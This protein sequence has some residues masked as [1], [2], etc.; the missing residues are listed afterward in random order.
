[1]RTL[2]KGYEY[3][4]IIDDTFKDRDTGQKIPYMVL[5]VE[6]LA[7]QCRQERISVPSNLFEMV[8]DLEVFRG[9]L[10]DLTVDITT[11]K[12]SRIRLVSVDKIYNEADEVFADASGLGFTNLEEA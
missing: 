7:D 9:D 5:L 10:I 11:G 2:L 12:Y 6:N 8:R 3:R 4:T 1:M